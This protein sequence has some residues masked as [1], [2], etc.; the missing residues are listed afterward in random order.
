MK[1]LKQFESTEE[2]YK[3]YI[4]WF[5]KDQEGSNDYEILKVTSSDGDKY[6]TTTIYYYDT[7]DNKLKVVNG[8]KRESWSAINSKQHILFS[9]DN[10]GD[11]L[12]ELEYVRTANK[13]NL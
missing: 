6:W 4:L 1:H 10:V 12:K 7:D 3:T 9:S 11:C 8:K 5:W 13:Y 2:P